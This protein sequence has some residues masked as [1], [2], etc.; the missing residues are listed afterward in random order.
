MAPPANIFAERANHGKGSAYVLGVK[1]PSPTFTKV[2]LVPR[3]LNLAVVYRAVGELRPDPRNARSHPKKQI[4]QIA[5][6]IEAFGFSNPVL[7]DD[8][9]VVIAGHGRLLA[10]KRLNLQRVPTIALPHLSEDERR[11][12]RLADN[13]IAQNSGWDGDLLKLE[14]QA[15][16]G[17]ELSFDM[18]VLG[19]AA[20]EIDVVLCGGK[21]DPEEDIVPDAPAKPTTRTGDIWVLGDHRIGCGDSRDE[22]F[23]RRVMGCD[24]LADAAF[25]DPPYNV[26]IAKHANVKS[27]HREF[28]M[29]C[30]EMNSEDY[31]I[32][33][34]A[35]LKTTV[36]ASRNG[37]VNFVCI[38]WRHMEL[39]RAVGD[40]FYGALLNLCIWNKSNAGM[41]S[42]YRSKH[43][44]V[45]VYRVG[46][47][48]HFNAI[49]LGRH[50]RNRSNVWEYPSVTSPR[51][52]RRRD[53]ELHPTVKPV[54][55]VAD[56]IMDVT[57][58]GE[59]VLDPFLGSG[60]TLMAAD[61][62]GRRCRGVEI[63]P[64]YVDV[65]IERW[66]A[67][68]GIEPKLDPLCRQ[69]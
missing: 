24:S 31:E 49:E 51:G 27:G 47:K 60:T 6:S 42:L 30:G 22:G 68:T 45:F 53:L 18:K 36:A 55:M 4:A 64:A 57:R 38:D 8:K 59:I 44:L 67:M 43:E 65:A 50:G 21:A 17:L 5:A 39:L 25:V 54:A 12:L 56:A 20:G 11:A 62:T 34:N 61:R 1:A 2:A 19:F 9:G 48:K 10:A 37:A 16:G 66:V 32:F 15:L 13:R 41:G 40:K 46:D 3:D 33:L 29:A 58:R 52:S 28:A 35:S 14:L 7:V 23:V 26:E 69:E 63:D